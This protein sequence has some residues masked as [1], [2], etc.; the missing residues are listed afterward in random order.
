[1]KFFLLCCNRSKFWVVI[2]WLQ[3]AKLL[4]L[5]QNLE[6]LLK[7][8]ALFQSTLRLGREQVKPEPTAHGAA[9]VIG[10]CCVQQPTRV[11]SQA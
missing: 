10:S 11:C 3:N 1:M 6:F 2:K 8:T 7:G 9:I 4:V 5:R